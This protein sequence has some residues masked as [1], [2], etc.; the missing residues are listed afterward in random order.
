MILKKESIMEFFYSPQQFIVPL[1]ANHKEV[2]VFSLFLMLGQI[3][4]AVAQVLKK[5]VTLIGII[6]S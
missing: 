1:I 4:N 2:K 5:I 6:A 3:L